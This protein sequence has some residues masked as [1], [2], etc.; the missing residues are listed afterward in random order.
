MRSIKRTY[1]QSHPLVLELVLLG[2]LCF[3]L[4]VLVLLELELVVVG[5][6]CFS[7]LF[8]VHFELEVE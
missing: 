6:F 8:L 2:G 1:Q 4:L 7:L 3:S 5:G